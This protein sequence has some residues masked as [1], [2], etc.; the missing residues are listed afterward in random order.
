MSVE[1]MKE[2][3]ARYGYKDIQAAEEHEK[4]K[5]RCQEKILDTPKKL[6]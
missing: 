6:L 4:K 2:T 1:V 5:M 3:V